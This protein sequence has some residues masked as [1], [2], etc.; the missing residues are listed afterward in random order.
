MSN[1]N[2]PQTVSI[3]GV[4]YK[5]ED[6]SD[7]AKRLIDHVADLDRKAASMDFQ[8][9]QIQLGRDT[10]FKLLKEALESAPETVN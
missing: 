8:R 9:E 6:L 4:E 3:D 10:A 7:R 2:S 1:Q 5:V